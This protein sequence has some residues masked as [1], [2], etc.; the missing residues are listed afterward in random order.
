MG[1]SSVH[2]RHNGS[3]QDCNMQ[4]LLPSTDTPDGDCF[5]HCSF[6]SKK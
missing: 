1:I 2:M 4:V 6:L 5:Y 3:Q